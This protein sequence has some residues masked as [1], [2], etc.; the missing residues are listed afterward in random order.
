MA[1]QKTITFPKTGLVAQDSYIKLI[2][3]RVDS[4]S[5]NAEMA[6]VINVNFIFGVYYDSVAAKTDFKAPIDTIGITVKTTKTEN[7]KV[8]DNPI[9]WAYKIAKTYDIFK[10]AI[11]V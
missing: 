11:D 6:D 4:L 1:F 7:A 9:K 10:D 3:L 2:A 5:S 8:V